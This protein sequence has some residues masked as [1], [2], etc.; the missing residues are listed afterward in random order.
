MRTKSFASVPD[1]VLAARGLP[2]LAFIDNSRRVYGPSSVVAVRRGDACWYEVETELTAD[3]LNAQ[4]GVNHA[5]AQ[6]MLLGSIFGWNCG[7]ACPIRA[8]RYQQ[9]LAVSLPAGQ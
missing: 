9:S 1:D 2:E 3:E 7:P 6:A 8:L 4:H 5:Q